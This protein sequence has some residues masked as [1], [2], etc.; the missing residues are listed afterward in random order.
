MTV[1]RDLAGGPAR[2]V[3]AS[4]WSRP[5]TL[6]C[7]LA[8]EPRS[9]QGERVYAK[10]GD[11]RRRCPALAPAWTGSTW[12]H[13]RRGRHWVDPGSAVDVAP[14][15]SADHGNEGGWSWWQRLHT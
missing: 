3:R 2:R 10:R 9:R 11:W 13:E 7:V 4:G 5:G 6:A 15:R 1:A 14:S 12:P 8:R